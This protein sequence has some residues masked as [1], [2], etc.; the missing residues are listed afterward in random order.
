MKFLLCNRVY[1]VKSENSKFKYVLSMDEGRAKILNRS[2]A[3]KG[4]FFFFFFHVIWEGN[5]FLGEGG[6]AKVSPTKN[7]QGQGSKGGKQGNLYSLSPFGLK[8]NLEP[9]YCCSMGPSG[10][11]IVELHGPFG[12]NN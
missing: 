7:R 4:K 12:T 8:I 6:R 11:P 3:K 10:L 5:L 2:S 9:A 1:A